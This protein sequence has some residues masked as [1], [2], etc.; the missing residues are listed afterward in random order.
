MTTYDR[1]APIYY[2]AVVPDGNGGPTMRLDDF[3]DRVLS[4][5]YEDEEQKAD[6]VTLTIDNFDLALYDDPAFKHG[7]L[8]D[9]S[10]GYAGR[11]APTRRC[12]V[13][14]IKGGKTVTVT[15]VAQSILM[16]KTI[17][18]R[19]FTNS[20]YSD[21][22]RTLAREAGFGD[23]AIDVEETPVV[24]ETITQ[25]RLSDAQFIRRLAEK[26]GYEF[27][28]DHE[29]FHFHR[30]RLDQSPTRT[31][32]YYIDREGGDVLD[33]S[34]DDDIT[35]PK[36]RHRRR[37]RNLTERTEIDAEASNETDTNRATLA[38]VASLPTPRT[39]AASPT[40]SSP[41][42]FVTFDRDTSAPLLSG[43]AS[44][45]ERVAS[46]ETAPT[47]AQDSTSAEREA[48]GTNRRARQS[49]IKLKLDVVGD[50][51]VLAKT[52][53]VVEGLGTRLSGRYYVKR[54]VSTLGND[55]SYKV[56]LEVISD[57]HGGHARRSRAARDLELDAREE[58]N[59]GAPNTAPPADADALE[60]VVMFDRDTSAPVTTFR[61]RTQR[62][63][64]T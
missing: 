19:S 34:L 22:A 52:V 8:L 31:F 10:W 7:M 44:A 38:P 27:Y 33:F 1:S 49:A 9:V 53:I 47:T 41:S 28:V 51:Y 35:K 40:A 56:A 39:P 13:Q 48:V 50:P 62:R 36:A 18:A 26:E 17:R 55:G 14:S 37:G 4:F 11:M 2:V 43:R 45:D 12:V 29:G 25:A 5:K 15:A 3:S 30:R 46:E 21:V 42:V 20:R 32:V 59:T 24:H 58:P 16:N 61:P 60:P 57:G 6:R 63:G 23:D 64:G 54:V